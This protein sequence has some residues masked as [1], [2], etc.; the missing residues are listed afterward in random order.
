MPLRART[1]VEAVAVGVIG[2]HDRVGDGRLAIDR[3]QSS[4][5]DERCS[6]SFEA[7]I[8]ATDAI[9]AGRSF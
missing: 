1:I 3:E 7:A 4:V 9:A 6:G 5:E 8:R 2:K